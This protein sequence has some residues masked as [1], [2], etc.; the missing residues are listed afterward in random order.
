MSPQDFARDTNAN[1]SKDH[2]F[3]ITGM[4]AYASKC[5]AEL[6]WED[7]QKALRNSRAAMQPAPTPGFG[8]APGFGSTPTPFG[9]HSP[10]TLPRPAIK[11]GHAATAGLLLDKG[12]AVV[13]GGNDVSGGFYLL[14]LL[15][16][17]RLRWWLMEVVLV[18]A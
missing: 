15:L 1:T 18:V 9:A 5:V 10:E 4:P 7:Y 14:M 2:L 11:K 8:L 3:C 16:L 17:L 6:R 13:H 12:G